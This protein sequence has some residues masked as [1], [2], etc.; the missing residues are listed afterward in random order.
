MKSI[1]RMFYI[2]KDII[3]CMAFSCDTQLLWQR[4]NI[5]LTDLREFQT[6]RRYDAPKAT[7]A[8]M[9]DDVTCK[10]KSTGDLQ[11]SLPRRERRGSRLESVESRGYPVETV[12]LET[13]DSRISRGFDDSK[14][15]RKGKGNSWAP[16]PIRKNDPAAVFPQKNFV[17]SKMVDEYWSDVPYYFLRNQSLLCK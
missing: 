14:A 9:A 16:K 13:G 10:K 6:S 15:P 17:A 5:T 8:T 11:L 7:I 12:S 4:S 3:Y 1:Q 2:V